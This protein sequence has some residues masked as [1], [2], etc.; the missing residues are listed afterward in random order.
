MREHSPGNWM[1]LYRGGKKDAS[2]LP[3][4]RD[5]EHARFGSIA[6]PDVHTVSSGSRLLNPAL[7]GD[8]TSACVSGV[9]RLVPLSTGST[10]DT[11]WR[12]T[13]RDYFS[14][15]R[16]ISTCFS[17]SPFFSRRRDSAGVCLWLIYNLTGCRFAVI[18]RESPRD[19]LPRS[20]WRPHV[21]VARCEI[22]PICQKTKVLRKMEVS[23]SNSN[24]IISSNV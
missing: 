11:W 18:R 7:P 23:V 1:P 14:R 6:L 10:L 13:G 9:G 2:D 16:N 22:C 19:E 15:N 20:P 5:E 8:R 17:F 24:C 12:R 3:C 21:Y 4:V